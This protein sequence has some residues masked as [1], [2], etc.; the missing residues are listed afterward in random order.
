VDG[1]EAGFLRDGSFDLI[2]GRVLSGRGISGYDR[3]H[4]VVVNLVFVWLVGNL[5]WGLMV[6]SVLL[7]IR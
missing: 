6:M 1:D 7:F 3:I 2:P 5:V 4:L